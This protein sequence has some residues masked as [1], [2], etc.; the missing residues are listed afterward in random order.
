MNRQFPLAGLLRLRKMQEDQAAAGM[1]RA[2]S[3]SRTAGERRAAA[4][5]ELG[6]SG[7][8]ASSSASLLAIAAARA[9]SQ[10]MLAD[11]DA[12]AAA[13]DEQLAD[14]RADYT[15]ARRSAVGLEKLEGRHHAERAAADLL[16]EQGVLDE[17]ASTAWHRNAGEASA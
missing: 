14:A 11:L 10:S 7:A 8:T 4:R 1:S 2:A 17:I 16:A 13:A 5:T 6:D 9:S 15:Q 3:R 12:L